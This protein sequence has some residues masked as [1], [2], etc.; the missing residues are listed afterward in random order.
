MGLQEEG[1]CILN[2]KDDK[3][4]HFYHITLSNGELLENIR[5]EGSLEW[6]LSGIAAHLVAVEDPDGRKIVLSKYHIVK[7]ELIKVED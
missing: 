3:R 5:I 6:N 2:K 4:V 7:A 1:A